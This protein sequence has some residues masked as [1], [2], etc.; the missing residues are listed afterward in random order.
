MPL[1]SKYLGYRSKSTVSSETYKLCTKSAQSKGPENI[2][3]ERMFLDL[4]AKQ[5]VDTPSRITFENKKKIRPQLDREKRFL[6]ASGGGDGP[7]I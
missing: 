4:M 3:P 7:G 5:E 2:G 1:A 6:G